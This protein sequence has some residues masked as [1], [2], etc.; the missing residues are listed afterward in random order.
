M[1]R[2]EVILARLLEVVLIE[3]LRSSAGA[4]CRQECCVA[5]RT[6]EWQSR[7]ADARASDTTLDNGAAGEAVC[8]VTLDIFR[9]FS[10][11]WASRR[12]S[13]CSPGEWAWPRT[14]CIETKAPSLKSRSVSATALSA[15]SALPS[16]GVSECR[17]QDT[18]SSRAT[19]CPRAGWFD[20]QD[21]SVRLD[22]IRPEVQHDFVQ[23][24][25]EQKQ[26]LAADRPT[27]AVLT[28]GYRL[29]SGPHNRSSCLRVFHYLGE[30]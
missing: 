23:H 14:F 3:A 29:H 7:Y 12:W 9:R 10:R 20:R 6:K 19:L 8:S 4:P 26:D 18:F 25:I 22:R 5:L 16:V 11:P 15:R 24:W 30:P 27:L 13:I 2:P 28:V 21:C 1:L 17:R